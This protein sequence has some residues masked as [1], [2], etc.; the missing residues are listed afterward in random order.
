MFFV[1]QVTGRKRIRKIFKPN[2][3]VV[4]GETI[5]NPVS[6]FEFEKFA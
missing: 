1:D 2:T 5:T 6:V 3:K 4:F